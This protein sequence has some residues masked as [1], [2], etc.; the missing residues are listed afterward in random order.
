MFSRGIASCA[1]RLAVASLDSDVA[2][3]MAECCRNPYP[4]VHLISSRRSRG[5]GPSLRIN[6]LAIPQIVLLFLSPER[7]NKFTVGEPASQQPII[8]LD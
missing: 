8:A 1:V 3:S 7:L 5:K 6:N 4:P 2:V